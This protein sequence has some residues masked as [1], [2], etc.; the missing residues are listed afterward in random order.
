MEQPARPVILIPAFDP[1]ARL[2]ALVRE[3]RRDFPRI[4]LVDDGSTRGREELAAAVEAGAEKLLVHPE[5]R[6]KGAALKTG[7]AY[8]LAAAGEPPDVITADADGQHTP[9]DIRKI[10]DGLRERRRG[11]VLGVRAFAGRV[12]F[13]SRFG[14]F[15]TRWFFFLLTGLF[16]RD[17]Q[18]GLRGI[19]GPLLPR[20]AALPGA[21]YE[22]E[23]V[24]LADARRHEEPPLQVPIETVYLDGNAASHFSPLKDTVRIYRAL[25]SFR[26][27]GRGKGRS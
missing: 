26:F 27:G 17:T 25:F 11:L 2:V 21:R 3:L 15:W 22:Y 19:P 10:A 8:L 18:T 16:V 23:M 1:D 4:V 9:A 13:R 5:N 20:V 12:P 24:M 14:N 7:F 6:G